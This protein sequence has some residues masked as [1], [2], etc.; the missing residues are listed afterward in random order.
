MIDEGCS[1]SWSLATI[2]KD[3]TKYVKMCAAID[4]DTDNICEVY[5]VDEDYNYLHVYLQCIN[6]D[7][8][9]YIH[10]RISERR[11]ESL[12][13]EAEREKEGGYVDKDGIYVYTPDEIAYREHMSEFHGWNPR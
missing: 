11:Y 8:K 12:E 3:L 10:R 13:Y 7:I 9:S 1:T 6:P 2:V 5:K 4:V